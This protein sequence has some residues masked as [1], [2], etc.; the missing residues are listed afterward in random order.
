M[1]RRSGIANARSIGAAS[2]GESGATTFGRGNPDSDRE[3]SPGR[4]IRPAEKPMLWAPIVSPTWDATVQQSARQPRTQ[5]GSTIRAFEDDRRDRVG[6]RNPGRGFAG[7]PPAGLQGEVTQVDRLSG[8][9]EISLGSDDGLVPGHELNVYRNPPPRSRGRAV[10]L[11]RMRI[12]S[13]SP[14]QAVGEMIDGNAA[15]NVKEK[16]RVST[17]RPEE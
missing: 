12:L 7:P 16:D 6:G 15:G 13:L 1:D 17:G 2:V 9:V 11:G 4:V 14:D 3:A 10:S 5:A 8:R